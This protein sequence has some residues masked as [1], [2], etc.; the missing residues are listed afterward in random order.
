MTLV[1]EH[2]RIQL[3]AVATIDG[4]TTDI[5]V[6]DRKKDAV[7]NYQGCQCSNYL[8]LARFP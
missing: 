5:E 2:R 1:P 7:Y 6:Y 3:M 8:V 4:D